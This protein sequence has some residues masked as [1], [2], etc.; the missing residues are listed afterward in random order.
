M[1]RLT[2]EEFV[3]KHFDMESLDAALAE[4]AKHH[5][6]DVEKEKQT[7]IE[8]EYNYYLANNF[9]PENDF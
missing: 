9:V 1:T 8:S 3:A 2:K 4:V 7:L 6:I 5:D